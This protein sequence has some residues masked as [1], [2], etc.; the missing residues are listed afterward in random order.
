MREYGLLSGYHRLHYWDVS[1]TKNLFHVKWP[2]GEWLMPALDTD[3]VRA[4]E[5]D[6]REPRGYAFPADGKTFRTMRDERDDTGREV[7]VEVLEVDAASG[8]TGRSLLK[9][10]YTRGS[11]LSPDGGRL[12]VRDENLTTVT[13]YDV[14]RGAK[15]SEHAFPAARLVG[16]PRFSSVVFSEGGRRLV[17][18]RGVGQTFVV[19]AGTGAAL[20]A[21]DGL[22]AEL[23]MPRAHAFSGDDRLLAVACRT[24]QEG[25]AVGG[26]FRPSDLTRPEYLTVWDT[27]TG[28]VLKRWPGSVGVAFCPTRPVLAILEPNGESETR[29]GF[30]DFAAEAEKK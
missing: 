22:P 29:I 6:G 28:R 5:F 2:E 8:K 11:V 4:V 13:V 25:K 23:T 1:K 17:V 20:P 30:W 18:A 16:R 15:V 12:A 27:E 24:Y 21:L 10:D 26:A 19:D 9:L 14:D 7:K 3:Q